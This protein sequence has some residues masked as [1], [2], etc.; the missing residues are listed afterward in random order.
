MITNIIKLARLIRNNVSRLIGFSL[1]IRIMMILKKK[2]KPIFIDSDN[3][4]DRLQSSFK[5][6]PEYG[7]DAKSSWNRGVLRAQELLEKEEIYKEKLKV[8]EVACG[9]GMTGYVLSCFGYDVTLNDLEDWRDNRCKGLKMVVGDLCERLSIESNSFDL[10][11]S[12]NSFEHFSDPQAAFNEISRVTKPG[13]IIK[14]EFGPLYSSPW[15]LHA[16]STIFIPY[17]QFLFSN[18]FIEKKIHLL[19]I[20]D[21]GKPRTKLQS[22]NG[23]KIEQFKELWNNELFFVSDYSQIIANSHLKIIRQFPQS[24]SGYNL[25]FEDVITQ[26]ISVTLL[27]R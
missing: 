22:T 1:K 6:L 15:G 24:F 2:E 18:T 14:L 8:L 3:I 26:A 19:G 25:S 4:F 27:K 9:D 13:G 20:Y 12:Y 23:W 21:L 10:V 16:F 17:V 7:Y 5:P 11:I